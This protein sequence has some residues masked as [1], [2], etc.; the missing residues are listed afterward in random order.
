[1]R[2]AEKNCGWKRDIR[3]LHRQNTAQKISCRLL[4]KGS[5]AEKAVVVTSVKRN[6]FPK[7]RRRTKRIGACFVRKFDF[8]EKQTFAGFVKNIKFDGK[9]TVQRDQITTLGD[10][11][12]ID[13]FF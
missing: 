3:I 6:I 9:L 10:Q 8:G 7:P 4:Q 12:T 1:M 5:T 11:F 13:F 2:A